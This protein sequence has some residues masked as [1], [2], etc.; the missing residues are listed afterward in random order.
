MMSTEINVL[1]LEVGKN[2]DFYPAN[3]SIPSVWMWYLSAEYG[4]YWN[5]SYIIA[6][7]MVEFTLVRGAYL[8][9]IYQIYIMDVVC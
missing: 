5:C 2:A 7:D 6:P 3:R 1:Q 4:G 9:S 8:D